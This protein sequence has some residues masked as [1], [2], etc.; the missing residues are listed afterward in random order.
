MVDRDRV[1]QLRGESKEM[2]VAGKFQA[3]AQ[4]IIRVSGVVSVTE[5]GKRVAAA[6]FPTPQHL[7]DLAPGR[8]AGGHEQ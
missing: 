6:F 7:G 4:R 8:R 3:A 1:H 2:A 5:A